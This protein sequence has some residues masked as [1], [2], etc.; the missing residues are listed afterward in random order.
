MN[1]T[2]VPERL[3]GKAERADNNWMRR[4][5]AVF[6][7]M[8]MM[9]F[10]LAAPASS[11]T[12]PRVGVLNSASTLAFAATKGWDVAG[13]QQ[14][15]FDALQRV[16]MNPVWVSDAD[17]EDPG[18]LAGFDVIVLPYTRVMN[19]SASL[20]VRDWIAGGGGL[21]PVLASPREFPLP[22]GGW[23]LWPLEMNREAWEWGPLSEAYQMDYLNDPTPDALDL[24]LDA[25]G[26]NH[27]IVQKALANLGLTTLRLNRPTGAGA[28]FARVASS[29]VQP[30][31]RFSIT[32]P[33][34]YEGVDV[35]QY[36]GF[37]AAEATRYG[38]GRIVYFDTSII[39]FFP[40][41]SLALAHQLFGGVQQGDIALE[42]F[43]QSV[44]WAGQPDGV[45]GEIIRDARTWGEI[46]AWGSSIYVRQY[47]ENTGNVPVTGIV[48]TRIFD[49]GGS[50]VYESGY[51]KFGFVAGDTY[52]YNF[53]WEN[54]GALDDGSY[55]VEVEYRY[56]FPAYD[57]V[58][59][60]Y[61]LVTRGQGLDLP[62]SRIG[63][64]RAAGTSRYATAVA[65]AQEAFTPGAATVYIA[66]GETFPDALAAG[67]VAGFE[68]S[69]ILLTRR[70]VLPPET[71]A[72]LRRLQP[73]S[74]VVLGGTAAI[75]TSVEQELAGYTSGSVTR[76]AGSNRY[77]TAAALSARTYS[78][79]VPAA[80]IV[81]GESF[82]DGLTAGPAA[83]AVGGPVLLVHPGWI[84]AETLAE[85]QRLAPQKIYVIGGSVAVSDSVASN[86]AGLTT[87]AVERLAGS[88]RYYTAQAV[89]QRIFGPGPQ[90]VYMATGESFPDA[91][92]AGPAAAAAGGPLLLSQRDT[93]PYGGRLELTRLSPHVIV[94][95]GGAT[96]ISDAIEAA[97]WSW[98]P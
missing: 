78:P 96:V 15:A 26:R 71:A 6:A 88:N 59:K 85:L 28:E 70:S 98:T 34:S 2:I 83:A 92:S 19:E 35:T 49:P 61:A 64:I 43:K 47:F 16:G 90:T 12:T 5:A 76:V 51:D 30:L 31:L 52:M 33:G 39:D 81:T 72:E 46:D 97:L 8:S 65:V 40:E 18:Q 37:P 25:Q 57:R 84:P 63:V 13:R 36:D 86:L 82:P 38:L 67:A 60:E 45:Y 27:P 93:I 41:Y 95:V 20:T 62:T 9:V 11:V 42:L 22:G 94:V 14:A 66:T 3:K 21:V 79:G 68:H 50:L 77:A 54:G 69:P 29:N 7:I 17:L 91:L 48:R 89:S 87:G 75:A 44:I 58:Y 10:G 80:F 32:N 4:V 24:L 53:G 56:S 55:R 73:A 23:G 74:I 1:R